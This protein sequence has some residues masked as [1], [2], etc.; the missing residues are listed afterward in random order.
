MLQKIHLAGN[1]SRSGLLFAEQGTYP[2]R[3]AIDRYGRGLFQE[4]VPRVFLVKING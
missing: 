4:D 3:P 2:D 1:I